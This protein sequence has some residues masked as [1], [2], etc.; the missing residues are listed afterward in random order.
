MR[1]GQNRLQI[2]QINEKKML[3]PAVAFN[4]KSVF[5]NASIYRVL[6]LQFHYIL[7]VLSELTNYCTVV[8]YKK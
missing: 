1:I 8:L 3:F 2:C 4:R 7:I 6:K 5:T